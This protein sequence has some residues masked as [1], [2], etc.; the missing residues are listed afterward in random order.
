LGFLYIR[1]HKT[2]E[3]GGTSV[4]AALAQVKLTL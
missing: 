3:K 2:E 1:R 4:V